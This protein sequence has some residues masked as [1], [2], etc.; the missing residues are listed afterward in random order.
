[1]S[2][3]HT[4][5]IETGG[6]FGTMDPM[7]LAS[8][9]LS[10]RLKM[11]AD[12]LAVSGADINRATGIAANRWSQYVNPKYKRG[13]TLDAAAR[14]CDAYGL[15]LDWIYRADPSGLPKHLHEKLAASEVA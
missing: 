1:M 3:I 9:T 4:S 11:T 14:L 2:T 12:A 10:R 15:T 6:C 5:A 7:P 13:I 8:K